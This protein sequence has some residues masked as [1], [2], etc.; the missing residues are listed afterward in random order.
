MITHETF[1]VICTTKF[2]IPRY[3]RQVRDSY[4]WVLVQLPFPKRKQK[5]RVLNKRWKVSVHKQRK[6][7]IVIKKTQ[8]KKR[9]RRSIQIKTISVINDFKINQMQLFFVSYW[10]FN[11]MVHMNLFRKLAIDSWFHKNWINKVVFNISSCTMLN[12]SLNNISSWGLLNTR[13]LL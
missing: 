12:A 6:F 4:S 3:T 11:H 5:N 9:A 8:N 2:W 7:I 13:S 10:W 1:N